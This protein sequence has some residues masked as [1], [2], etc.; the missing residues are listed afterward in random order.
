[1]ETALVFQDNMIIQRDK[2]FVIWGTGT[3]GER[4]FGKIQG[5]MET[6]FVNGNGKWLLKFPALETSFDET[7]ELWDE[8]CHKVIRQIAVGEVWLAAGQSGKGF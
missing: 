3:P 8:H 6:A 4:I 5:R 7:M 2:P 1:M